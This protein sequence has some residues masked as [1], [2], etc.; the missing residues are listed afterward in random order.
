MLKNFVT[1]TSLKAFY[2]KLAS[3]I[4][5][6]QS[7]YATQITE[8]FNVLL[9]D[10]RSREIEARRLMV[11]LDLKRAASS[12]A[13]QDLLLTSSAETSTT[14]GTH[15]NGIGGFNRYVVNVSAITS[16]GYAIKL[17]GSNEQGINASTEPTNWTDIVTITPTATGESSSVFQSEFNYYRYVNTVTGSTITYTV[18][19]YE[20]WVDRLIA[21]KAFEMIFRDFAK[22]PGDIWDE[23]SKS[24]ANM[25]LQALQSHKFTVDDDD[26]NLVNS[27]D[28]LNQDGQV[29]LGR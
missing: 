6:T 25:Y 18:G 24:H 17:Q 10:M 4:W 11:P 16:T 3:Y 2:P 15:I 22:Q 8:A 19:I 21:H 28:V 1:D 7:D 5:S 27:N 26:N 9:D 12:T 20:T 13:D 14:M 23:R 29:L